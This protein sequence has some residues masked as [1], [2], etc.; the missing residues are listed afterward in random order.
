[1]WAAIGT[2]SLGVYEVAREYRPELPRLSE[3]LYLLL[4]SLGIYGLRAANRSLGNPEDL[5]TPVAATVTPKEAV[6]NQLPDAAE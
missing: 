6:S 5:P 2:F 1:V 4:G 3:G